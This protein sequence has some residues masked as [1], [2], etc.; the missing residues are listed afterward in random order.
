MNDPLPLSPLFTPT[1]QRPL[2]GMAV[3]VVED[4]RFASDAL[5]MMCVRSGARI[6]RADS[7]AAARRH[8]KTYLPS[9]VIVDL[10]LPDGSGTELIEE[11]SH[12]TPKIDVLLATSGD[13]FSEEIAM[14]A[15]A[16]GFLAKPLP[17]LAQFQTEILSRLPLDRQPKGP[18]RLPEDVLEVDPVALRDDLLHASDTLSTHPE[19]AL[20]VD[21]VAQFLSSVARTARDEALLGA[22]KT[23]SA[24]QHSGDALAQDVAQLNTLLQSRLEETAVI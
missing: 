22:V 12:T 6:R 11:L 9:V 10:G 5:R 16:D 15:G 21:Y 4:S 7:L 24:T 3:L 23:V 14:A 2:L 8:L 17:G 1:A 19:D 18:R 13:E 20:V